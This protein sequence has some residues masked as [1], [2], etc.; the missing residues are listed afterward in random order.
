VCCIVGSLLEVREGIR[1]AACPF[2]G[3]YE[4]QCERNYQE[5]DGNTAGFFTTSTSS[6]TRRSPPQSFSRTTTV[7]SQSPY[8]PDLPLP[9]IFVFPKLKDI[10]KGSRHESAAEKT[11]KIPQKWTIFLR[12]RKLQAENTGNVVGIVL[13]YEANISRVIRFNKIYMVLPVF[14][15][16]GWTSAVTDLVPSF[17]QIFYSPVWN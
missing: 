8:G 1:N 15:L 7:V 12:N 13:M 2:H 9:N 5:F 14:N 3:V 10:I 16:I 4:K 6:R 17:P 11:V